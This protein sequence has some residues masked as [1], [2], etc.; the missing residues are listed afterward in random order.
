MLVV[1]IIF[2]KREPKVYAAE[3]PLLKRAR[4]SQ[5]YRRPT[6]NQGKRYFLLP[7]GCV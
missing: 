3:S 7:C 6:W 4:R 1:I 2:N 5:I